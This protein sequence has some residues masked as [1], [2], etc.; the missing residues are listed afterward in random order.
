VLGHFFDQHEFVGI[1]GLVLAELRERGFETL[2]AFLIQH[3]EF[4]TEAVAQ[5]VLG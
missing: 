4:A 3:F 5:V 2:L 1:G